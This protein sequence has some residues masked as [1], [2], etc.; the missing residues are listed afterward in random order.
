[1]K[2]RNVFSAGLLSAALLLS[3]ATGCSTTKQKENLLT[4]A[5]FKPTP[6]I[7][8]AQKAHLATITPNK[9]CS[10]VRDGK[11][12][13]VFPDAK[14]EMLYVGQQPQYDE[15]KKL[16]QQKKLAEEEEMQRL[17]AESVNDAWGAW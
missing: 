10:V 15:Y 4:E 11:T 12:Y 6:A 7:T 13:Y 1:M 16:R 17:K 5:G 9:V 2:L 8:E 3:L 14:H